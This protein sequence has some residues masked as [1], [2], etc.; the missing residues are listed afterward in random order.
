MIYKSSIITIGF[1]VLLIYSCSNFQKKTNSKSSEDF[2]AINKE[3][4]FFCS[5]PI[6]KYSSTGIPC[7]YANIEKVVHAMRLDLGF[8]GAVV[9]R[10]P[11]FSLIEQKKFLYT[12]SL[13][14]VGG[15]EYKQDIYRIPKVEIEQLRFLDY[16]LTKENNE[17]TKRTSFCREKPSSDNEEAGQFG[18]GLFRKSNLLINV[19]NL[20]V[21][22]CDSIDT[23]SKEGYLIENFTKVPLLSDQGGVEFEASLFNQTMR[24]LLDTGSTSNFLKGNREDQ[25]LEE[26]I[27]DVKNIKSSDISIGSQ[28]FDSMPFHEIP[29]NTPF[30][31]QAVLGMP[32]FAE[33]VVFIDFVHE[34]IYLARFILIQRFNQLKFSHYLAINKK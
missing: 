5:T 28:V 30:N 7:I 16:S 22:F 13:Y 4:R 18:S 15:Y 9:L 14:D 23:L 33:N 20:E 25:L 26:A 24:C 6:V 29:I 10:D 11:F 8:T 2:F 34:N 19:K 21:A 31:I 17:F 27:W 3:S 32:F 1:L 12:T